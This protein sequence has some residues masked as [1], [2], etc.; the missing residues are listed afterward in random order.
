MGAL[1]IDRLLAYHGDDFTGST[2]AL[3]ALTRGGVETVL[4]VDVPRSDLLD[5]YPRARAIGI[6][7]NSR[8]MTPAE[9]DATLPA[10]FEFLRSQRPKIVHY[11]VCSTFD[12]SPT[13][14][15]IGH[16]ID[17]G[18]AVFRNG[19]IPLVVGVPSLRRFCLF[20]NLF[21]SSGLDS[22]IFRLDRHPTMS[23]HPITPMAEADLRAHLALQTSRPVALVDIL[24]LASFGAAAQFARATA[25]LG[26]IILFDT[27]TEGHLSTIGQLIWDAQQQ[28]ER[29]LFV[30]GSSGI[31]Y[32]LTKH[33]E[34]VGIVQPA[35]QQFTI[36]DTPE[37]IPPVEQVLVLSGSCSPV[38]DRQ[39][40]WA[41][42]HGFSEIAL[43]TIALARSNQIDRQICEIA[44]SIVNKL[45]SG[46]SVV[47]HTSRGPNDARIVAMSQHVGQPA[48]T[49]PRLGVILGR[50]LRDVLQ[51][52]RVER[53]AVAGG[54]TSGEVARTIGIE[55]LEFARSFA[56]GAPICT[57]RSTD[58]N[59][60]GIEFIFKGGQ[61][62]HDDV[63][64][65]LL[66]M[67]KT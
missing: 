50:I 45:D 31:E 30:A 60:D 21:A 28:E 36:R 47:M 53:V 27:I 32:A 58:A 40:A 5:R 8:S 49:L 44:E 57:A 41:V 22:E 1:A 16:A 13:I 37:A 15:S 19:F 48:A 26:S 4:F 66:G 18:H 9:M 63:F 65:A 43:D 33:W 12:S 51:Q 34:T 10:A 2:D 61:V 3:E 25:G 38:T 23:R 42:A 64:G 24:A 7:G 20:G 67:P 11:K 56:P 54:D 39:I 62:G 6:A 52:R 14:G 29:P 46:R 55:A 35:I 59:V 17:I